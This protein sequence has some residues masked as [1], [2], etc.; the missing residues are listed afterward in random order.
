MST[1]K[2]FGL[3]KPKERAWRGSLFKRGTSCPLK[4]QTKNLIPEREQKEMSSKDN[5]NKR[6]EQTHGDWTIGPPHRV[7]L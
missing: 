6:P 5:E 2:G 3:Q 7:T 4:E 1:G